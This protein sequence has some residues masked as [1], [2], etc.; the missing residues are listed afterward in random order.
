MCRRLVEA[1]GYGC[2]DWESDASEVYKCKEGEKR[3]TECE[4]VLLIN[5][6]IVD[7]KGTHY[8]TCVKAEKVPDWKK[9]AK[10]L[11][12]HWGIPQ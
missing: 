7:R 3:G 10:A 6:G 11:F 2:G 1:W 9:S 8:P 12:E 5:G 4:E